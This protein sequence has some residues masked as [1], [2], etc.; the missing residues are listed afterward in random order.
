M[1]LNDVSQLKEQ[2]RCGGLCS[3]EGEDWHVRLQSERRL[4]GGS[5]QPAHHPA[6][7]EQLVG[8]VKNEVITKREN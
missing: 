2:T 5:G 1:A 3:E 4:R 7:E 6:S 8:I